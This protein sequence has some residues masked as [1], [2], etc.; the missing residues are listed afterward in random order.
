VFFGHVPGHADGQ[1]DLVPRPAVTKNTS[2]QLREI[3]PNLPQYCSG[4]ASRVIPLSPGWH[5]ELV[6]GGEWA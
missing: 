6:A 2:R 1:R 4:P 3:G 5:T